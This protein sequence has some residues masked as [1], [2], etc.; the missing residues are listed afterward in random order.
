MHLNKSEHLSNSL[1]FLSSGDGILIILLSIEAI[2]SASSESNILVKNLILC[3][4]Q[5][6]YNFLV[7]SLLSSAFS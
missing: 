2:N 5:M 7:F 3:F 1:P 4:E 6:L